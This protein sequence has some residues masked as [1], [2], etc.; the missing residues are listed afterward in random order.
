MILHPDHD[1]RDS[2]ADYMNFN[3]FDC[4]IRVVKR[5]QGKPVKVIFFSPEGKS[6][7]FNKTSEIVDTDKITN[8]WSLEK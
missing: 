2:F 7:V 5:E 3:P 4:G 8:M 1:I 6:F